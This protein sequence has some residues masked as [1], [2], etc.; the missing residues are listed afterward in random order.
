MHSP[1]V[2]S[3][4]HAP[5]PGIAVRVAAAVALPS[6][7]LLVLVAMSWDPL[8][9]LDGDIA[10]TTHRW[11]VD[12]PDTTQTFRILTDW[13]WDPWTMRALCAVAVLWLVLH[14]S[15][16]WLALWLT[17]TC[18]LGTLLQQGLKAAV[19]RKRPVWPDPVDSAHFAAYP[20]G[21]AMTATVVCG[22]M[23]WLLTCTAPDASCGVSRS[24]SPWCPSSESAS[25]VSGWA[26]TGRRTCS[27]AGC[28]ACW[29]SRSRWR[30][31]RGSRAPPSCADGAVGPSCRLHLR[32]NLFSPTG[33]RTVHTIKHGFGRHPA[34]PRRGG[35]L[36]SIS[37]R[38][39]LG[40]S[41]T[42]A[43]GAV[44]GAAGSAQA[45]EPD[46]TTAAESSSADFPSGSRFSADYSIGPID[47]SM[48]LTFSVSAM[49]TP[50]ENVITP[51]EIANLLNELAESRGWPAATFYGTPAPAPLT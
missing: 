20:S 3:P 46:A 36:S 42:T 10:R 51:I 9:A 31:T 22:L 43:A 13:V 41:G 32:T 47:A 16:W 38:S 29:R 30:R 50:T 7:L 19:D 2:D 5:G 39:L 12:D 17:A 37:R 40:Y 49:D 15:A 4:P 44:I 35:N 45:A 24:P 48:T 26:C 27:A 8:I 34:E 25:P 18:V 11:A 1:P 33:P 21:H 6:V 23:L 14:H 28:S